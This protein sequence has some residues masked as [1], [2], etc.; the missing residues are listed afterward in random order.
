MGKYRFLFLTTALCILASCAKEE[1]F[2]SNGLGP[3]DIAKGFGQ[4]YNNK[5]FMVLPPNGTNDTENLLTT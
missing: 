5:V 1:R 3:S 4:C 2:S